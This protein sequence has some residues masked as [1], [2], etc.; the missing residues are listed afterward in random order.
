MKTASGIASRVARLG[1]DL[2]IG[3]TMNDTAATANDPHAATMATLARMLGEGVFSQGR[4]RD[5]LRLF[6]PPARLIELLRTLKE[7]CGFNV[8]AELGATD[9][10][11]YPGR[12]RARFEVHYVL[13]NLDTTEFLVVKAGVDDP[14]PALPSAVPIWSGADWMERE[15]FDMFGIR[16]SGHPDLRRILMPEEFTAYPLRKDYPLRGRGE[17]HNFPRISREES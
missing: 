17:R 9:Y 11:G 14:D 12:T 1:C 4:F 16:F 3:P 13:R 7:H 10:L 6:V 2:H 8:L 5:N 15:V